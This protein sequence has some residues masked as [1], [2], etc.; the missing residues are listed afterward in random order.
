MKRI[1]KF[2]GL[3]ISSLGILFSSCSNTIDGSASNALSQ[4]VLLEKSFGNS[5]ASGTLTKELKVTATSNDNL[6]VFSK[7]RTIIPGKFSSDDL[8]FYLWGKDKLNNTDVTGNYVVFT[9]T[10]GNFTEGSVP[11]DLKVSQYTLYLAAYEK[12]A[13]YS[14]GVAYSTSPVIA[15]GNELKDALL[16]GAATVDLRNNESVKFYLSPNNL[17][18]NGD[19]DLTLTTRDGSTIWSDPRYYAEVSLVSLETGASVVLPSGK[20]AFHGATQM[21][22]GITSI[23]SPADVSAGAP[24]DWTA[25]GEIANA[26]GLEY[27]LQ[28]VPSGAYN[29]VVNF[30]N[31]LDNKSYPYSERLIVY[32]NQTT[33]QSVDIPKVIDTAPAKPTNFKVGYKDPDNDAGY[34]Y[35]SFTWTDNAKNEEYYVLQLLEL[36]GDKSNDAN[37]GWKEDGTNFG[38][39][40]TAV[41]A[42]TAV[43]AVPADSDG[44]YAAAVTAATNAWDA[45]V[46]TAAEKVSYDKHVY[47]N[48]KTY[49]SAGSLD[50]NS[51]TITLHLPLGK[52]YIARICAW[53]AFCNSIDTST[54]AGFTSVQDWVY[55][56]T[57]ALTST[58]EANA[59]DQ[60]DMPSVSLKTNTVDGSDADVIT[61]KQWP[62]VTGDAPAFTAGGES[63]PVGITR[64]TIEYNFNGGSFQKVD[65]NAV[66]P[67]N[68]ATPA[69]D[70]DVTAL[71][72]DYSALTSSVI[73]YYSVTNEGTELISP[74]AYN[75]ATGKYAS[76]YN[77]KKIWSSWKKDSADGTVIDS[78][79]AHPKI[80]RLIEWAEVLA[81]GA[82]LNS[83]K[84][85]VNPDKTQTSKVSYEI[86]NS[87]FAGSNVTST[88]SYYVNSS[89]GYVRTTAYSA[90]TDSSDL[91]AVKD[92]STD[93]KVYVR[94]ELPKYMASENLA[95]FANYNAT[96]AS[97]EMFND[98][99]YAIKPK[100][101]RILKQKNTDTPVP[102]NYLSGSETFD[103]GEIE[104]NAFKISSYYN[105]LICNLV[106]TAAVGDKEDI[107][108]TARVII[109]LE[110]GT[111]L[112]TKFDETLTVSNGTFSADAAKNGSGSTGK[113]PLSGSH[114]M[115]EFVIP[116][117]TFVPGKY[118]LTYEAY[119]ELRAET[120]YTYVLSFE[121]TNDSTVYTYTPT[122]WANSTTEYFIC[123]SVDTVT[124]S[125]SASAYS[126]Y[127]NAISGSKTHKIYRKESSSYFVVPET[128]FDVNAEYYIA[129]SATPKKYST[130][131]ATYASAADAALASANSLVYTR[132]GTTAY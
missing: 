83:D 117:S 81:S 36:S 99:N 10:S 87:T 51:K 111:R 44:G 28:S 1:A 4:F 107:Y 67:S 26:S 17:S 56:G 123:T 129:D 27:K 79:S 25:A 2:L 84:V 49:Y 125:S 35:A 91:D 97:Y 48:F 45:E 69:A 93:K 47:G 96:S 21:P 5:S 108:R 19:V 122:T 77:S 63:A 54:D 9:D 42:L 120:P 106:E 110:D 131:S 15:A 85:T 116:I 132:S 118:Q 128:D 46:P 92:K 33:A 53:N 57:Y 74:V 14:S 94:A 34:Y 80:F 37:L 16:Y 18:G 11:V 66:L 61:P 88:P 55:A 78:T 124:Y 127:A 121:L 23:T 104:G 7:S 38:L 100:N 30:I 3:A 65:A 89:F 126:T 115:W 52:V 101:V 13:E 50:K 82:A 114:T 75:Y 59:G 109:Q 105:K 64:Y 103:D 130:T 40:T 41:A 6:V 71:I 62:K 24:F 76:L 72:P 113:E 8:M 70:E 12:T 60:T 58:G 112:V 98:E 86:A 73:R 68:L 32:P 29:L 95:L 31:T 90:L 102:A 22:A 119:T 20:Y 39:S 43:A